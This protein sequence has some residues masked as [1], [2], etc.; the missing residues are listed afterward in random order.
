MKRALLGFLVL[1]VACAPAQQATTVVI[2]STF[3]DE[4]TLTFVQGGLQ[5]N[6]GSVPA[7]GTIVVVQG[8]ALKTLDASSPCKPNADST[9]LSCELGDVATAQTLGLSGQNVTASV[10]YRRTGS[11]RVY[12]EIAK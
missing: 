12:L 9:E 10:S 4:A 1:L 8:Q 2:D 5:F 11:N 3:G 7:L 6:P